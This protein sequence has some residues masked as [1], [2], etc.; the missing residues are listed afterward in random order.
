ME[1]SGQISLVINGIQF[2]GT[3][4]HDPDPDAIEQVRALVTGGVV[5]ALARQTAGS[6]V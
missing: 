6:K 4:R 5:Q 2:V 1:Q 3:V